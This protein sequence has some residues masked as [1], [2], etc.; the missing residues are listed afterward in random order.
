MAKQKVKKSKA[1]VIIDWVVTGIFIVLFV[2]FGIGQIDAMVN[3]KANHNQYLR[4]GFGCFYVWTESMETD[5]MV[6]DA[7]IT[8][9]DD[10]Q[11]VYNSFLKQKETK[12][13]E[14][15][16]IDI[17]FYNQLPKISMSDLVIEDPEF[18]NEYKMVVT[19]KVVTH[20]IREVHFFENKKMGEGR[21]VF[22][23]AGINKGAE[24]YDEGQYQV[25]TENEYLGVVKKS[26]KFLGKT[27]DFISSPFGLFIFLLI[28]AGYLV[29]TSSIDIVKALKQSENDNNNDG[30]TPS[31]GSKLDNLSEADKERL[32]QEMINKMLNGD[33]K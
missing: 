27:F 21:F 20:R 18:Q 3:L 23:C 22:I 25:V 10:I 8:H 15:I 9:K 7:I 16:H 32:K 19:N 6:G 4:Y 31:G 13:V 33:K 24:L 28:P 17:T 5:I 1:R 26:S 30:N 14:D 2:F 29:V 11:G 12:A